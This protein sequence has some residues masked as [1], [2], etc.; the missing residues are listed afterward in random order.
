MPFAFLPINS[1]L[2]SPLKLHMSHVSIGNSSFGHYATNYN[3]FNNESLVSETACPTAVG[4]EANNP[5]FNNID[6]LPQ[7]ASLTC[8]GFFEWEGEVKSAK[9]TCW[10]CGA[11]DI[12]RY[13]V[14][15]IMEGTNCGVPLNAV[16]T[17]ELAQVKHMMY[18]QQ[19]RLLTL[20]KE[21]KKEK[22]KVSQLEV[23]NRELSSGIVHLVLHHIGPIEKALRDIASSLL[24]FLFRCCSEEF[25]CK[26]SSPG[27]SLFGEAFVGGARSG[28][29]SSTSSVPS[30]VSNSP[31]S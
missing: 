15:P 18:E 22:A 2:P 20:E 31:I 7:H 26:D 12:Y 4:R 19:N 24:P 11:E 28:G 27:D 16:S 30:L 13:R 6:F 9:W 8:A 5:Q 17:P 10:G 3:Y 1:L 25:G 21:L 29:S 14:E 23:N